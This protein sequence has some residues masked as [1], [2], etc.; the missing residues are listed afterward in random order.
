MIDQAFPID[1]YMNTL[2]RLLDTIKYQD[3]NYDR[4]KRVKNLQYAYF[5]TAKHFA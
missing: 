1:Y 2:V 4:S 5:E 3:N